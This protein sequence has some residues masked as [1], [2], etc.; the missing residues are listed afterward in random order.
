ML[1]IHVS[2]LELEPVDDAL[3]HHTG[4][5][6]HHGRER[7]IGPFFVKLA[8]EAE[9]PANVEAVHDDVGEGG[10]RAFSGW[11]EMRVS[12]VSQKIN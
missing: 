10:F 2:R 7:N 5:R 11:S 4:R 8:R 12:F 6:F 3:L 1:P 9:G